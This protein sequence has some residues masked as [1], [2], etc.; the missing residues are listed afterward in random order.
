MDSSQTKLI[1]AARADPMHT[2]IEPGLNLGEIH[3][4]KLQIKIYQA[5][6]K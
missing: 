2:P 1:R 4:Q 5:S 6:Y 3:F